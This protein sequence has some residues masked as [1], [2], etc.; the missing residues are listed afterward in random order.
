MRTL[1]LVV[2]LGLPL[3]EI[4]VLVLVG[5]AIGAGPT[6]ALVIL[7][8]I[9]GVFVLRREGS[10]AGRRL[11]EA[12][13]RGELPVAA[14]FDSACRFLAGLLLILPGFLTDAL[15]ALLLV[16]WVRQAMRAALAALL[17]G[18]V[19][20]EVYARTRTL[21]GEYHEIHGTLPEREE[22]REKRP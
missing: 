10:L 5:Q 9:A 17:A 14:A 6:V 15:A 1:L 7:A 18:K 4:F 12:L 16:P 21:E 20:T 2:V 11:R 19:H 3:A 13:N 8:G 22:D